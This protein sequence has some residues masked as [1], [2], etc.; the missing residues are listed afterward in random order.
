MQDLCHDNKNSAPI[1]PVNRAVLTRRCLQI[2]LLLLLGLSFSAPAWA[3]DRPTLN[4]LTR[5]LEPALF[6]ADAALDPSIV[7]PDQINQSGLTPPSLWWKRQ[8]FGSDLITYWLAY[9]AEAEM[10]QR[11]DLIV[12]QQVWEEYQYLQRYTFMNQFGTTA[13]DFGYSTRVFNS[14]GEL[15][16]AHICRFSPA[17]TNLN[18]PCSIFLNPN[19]RGAFR[20]SASTGAL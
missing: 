14:R 7:T 13:K 20:G 6:E 16:G 8:Q 11:V 9:P 4:L 12:E 18:A 1:E 10:P 3:I 5:P 17:V 2:E 15:L 19:G